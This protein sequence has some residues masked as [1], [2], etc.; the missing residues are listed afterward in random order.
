MHTVDLHWLKG[1]YR[2]GP[3]VQV[4]Y[5]IQSARQGD[6][7]FEISVSTAIRHVRDCYAD[8]H[9][10]PVYQVFQWAARPVR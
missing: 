6:L 5:A 3:A 10:A 7:R 2:A 8:Q 1:C 4:I 9:C